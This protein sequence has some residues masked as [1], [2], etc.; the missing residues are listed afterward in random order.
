MDPEE[1]SRWV[2]E[3]LEIGLKVKLQV[4]TGVDTNLVSRAFEDWKSAIDSR[5]I[6]PDSDFLGWLDSWFK[7]SDSS[8]HKALDMQNPTSPLGRLKASLGDDLSGHQESIDEALEELR[9]M[10]ADELNAMKTHMGIESAV[11]EEVVAGARKGGQLENKVA[12]VLENQFKQSSDQISVVGSTLIEG[13]NRK[14]GDVEI[15][16]DTPISDALR[17]ILEVKSGSDYT[18]RGKHTLQD[19]MSE[20]M[21]LRGAQASIAV[22][23]RK[24]LKKSQG[25][26]T[27]VDRYRI[28][29]AVDPEA[30]DFTLLD[31][32]YRVLRYR[33]IQDASGG[34]KSIET[35]DSTLFNRLLDE[36]LSDLQM[37]QKM[38]SNLSQASTTIQGVRSDVVSQEVRVRAKV[39]ELQTLIQQALDD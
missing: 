1:S 3:A 6:G 4:R 27:D 8:F 5:I 15:L 2:D 26:W 25:I 32:A 18:L 35:L 19:Q 13:T 39:G 36:I 7:D 37:C 17:I 10:M 11:K 16:V 22:T 38:K 9:D 29:V 23:D 12:D 24:N 34:K 30:D 14:V 21:K 20:S 33:V 31:V 28:I